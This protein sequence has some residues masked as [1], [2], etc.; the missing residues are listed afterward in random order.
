MRKP[1]AAS[2]FIATL[3]STTAMSQTTPDTLTVAQAHA[4]VD[5][6]IELVS[7]N[8]VFEDKRAAIAAAIRAN[9]NAGQYDIANPAALAD[10]LAQD[11]IGI[12]HDKH[13]W[14]MYSPDQ[15]AALVRQ[16]GAK[17]DPRQ[18]AFFQRMAAR[19]NQGYAELRVL[20]GNIRYANLVNFIWEGKTPQAVTDAARFL[21]G[22]DAVIIDLR[23][24]GGGTPDAVRAMISYFMPPDHRLLMTFHDGVTGKTDMSKVTDKLDAPRMV[25]K[26]LYV[27][28][29]GNTGSA[30]EEFAYHIKEFKLGTL[31]GEATAGAANNDTAYPIAPGIVA[32]ISTGRPVHPVSGTNWEGAGIAPDVAVPA[33]KALDEAQLLALQTLATKSGADAQGIAWATVGEKARLASQP[34]LD[35][36]AMADYAASYGDRTIR[37]EDGALVY[38]RTGRPVLTMTLLSPDLFTLGEDD[39]T[40]VQFHRADGKIT[41]FDLMS[42]DGRTIAV[43]RSS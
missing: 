4:I 30:A 39:Q 24:N 31:V 16:S 42:Q 2:L 17:A 43:A 29:S 28:I 20:P 1:S 23:Q 36:S 7:K 12:S 21:G 18:D 32:S 27:L 34:K 11:V 35:A 13:M 25:G 22:G 3:L 37:I 38:Q 5:R 9:E 10:K 6:E 33:G 15:Y 14:V 40:R 41:G 26:P 19:S 8:Y